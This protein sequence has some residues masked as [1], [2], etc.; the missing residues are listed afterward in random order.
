MKIHIVPIVFTAIFLSACVAPQTRALRAG[1]AV[2]DA[3]AVALTE[4]AAIELKPVEIADLPFFP[5]LEHQCGPAALATLLNYT[6]KSVTPEQLS[7]QVY[8]PGRQGSFAVELVAAARRQGRLVY[9]LAKN[10]SSILAALEQGFP[11]LV[12]QNNGL[13]WVPAW[14]FSVVMG[15]DRSQEKIWLRSGNTK[16]LEL[17]FSTFERTWARSDYWAVLV[18]DPAHITDSL[19]AKVV[20]NELAL[21]EKIGAVAEAQSGFSRAVLNWPEQQGAW[22]GLAGTSLALGDTQ[23]A[24]STLRE[25]VRRRPVYGAGLNNLADLLLK[26]GRAQE[27]LPFAQRAVAVLSIP[28]TRSTLNAIHQALSP[29]KSTP[30]KTR[31]DQSSPSKPEAPNAEEKSGPEAVVIPFR[32]GGVA[33]AP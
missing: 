33:P 1:S 21:M 5:Q 17:S 12:L 24:E 31:P 10:L 3:S 8:V 13:S 9:P 4:V 19:D 23:L 26:S 20:I 29:Y 18:L 22:L 2:R 16:R 32:P 25:L 15:A 30:D 27:A 28:A 7:A 6:G 11:V 14:H